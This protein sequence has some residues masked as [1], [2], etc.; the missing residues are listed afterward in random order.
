MINYLLGILTGIVLSVLNIIL[1][2]SKARDKVERVVVK[3][4]ARKASIINPVPII[5]QIDI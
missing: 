3:A 1:F 2:F 5:D 4:F